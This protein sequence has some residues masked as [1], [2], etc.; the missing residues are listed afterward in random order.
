MNGPGNDNTAAVA[1]VDRYQP[2]A[3]RFMN[4]ACKRIAAQLV[5]TVDGEAWYG[6]SLREIL[7][8]VTATQARAHPITGA[9]SIG[10]I[11]AHVDGWVKLYARAL[12]G[13]PIPPWP[14]MPTEVDWPTPRDESDDA[15]RRTVRAFFEN[16]RTLV[17]RIEDFGDERL[18][19]VV[20][21]RTYDFGQLFQT[22]SL[23][24]AYHGGQI[25]LVKKMCE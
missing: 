23:H 19:S 22:A 25:V 7:E 20:P 21:G 2:H 14:G 12:E 10:E 6:P 4:T 24:A 3:N 9:H 13:T 8:G 17:Q 16:H 15:W 1:Y 18:A 5:S 11:V